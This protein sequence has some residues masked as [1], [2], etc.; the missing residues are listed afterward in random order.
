MVYNCKQD[1]LTAAFEYSSETLLTLM[2][3]INVFAPMLIM[4]KIKRSVICGA[5]HLYQIII[6]LCCLSSDLKDVID[7][8]KF[9]INAFL[10]YFTPNIYVI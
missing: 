10:N 1:S 8:V 6:I 7:P 9:E 3:I 2:F 5:Q 4:I